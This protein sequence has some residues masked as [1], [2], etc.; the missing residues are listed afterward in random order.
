NLRKLESA[1]FTKTVQNGGKVETETTIINEKGI[2]TKDKDDNISFTSPTEMIISDAQS[3]HYINLNK[4]GIT[5]HDEG[6]GTPG[7]KKET[8][9]LSSGS[10]T[11]LSNTTWDS[12]NITSGRAATEDQLQK[13]SEA[14]D[15]NAKAT[16]DFRLVA[17]T[18]TKGY[19]PDTSGTVTLDVKDKNHENK[20][21]YQVTISNVASK[22]D[23][24]KMLKEGF[25]VGEVDKPG[26]DGE[27]GKVE[28]VGKD[29]SAVVINGKDGS[30]GMKGKDGADGK[31]FLQ[32]VPGLDGADGETRMVYEADGKENVVATKDD[33]FFVEG[34]MGD[35]SIRQKLNTLLRIRGGNTDEKE[36]TENN[37]G[38]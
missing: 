8:T 32:K 17:S 5:I 23:V 27:D 15:A 28:V 35:K 30:I 9:S 31:L 38:V 18:D 29:G 36:L 26:K 37:I 34:D 21:A 14:V 7:S 1:E 33:G 4:S 24:D 22:S 2:L 19:T 20:D 3:K 12:K 13:V 10:L 11:G 25:T 16:T 6:D